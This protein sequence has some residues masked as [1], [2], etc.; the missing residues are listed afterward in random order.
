MRSCF[1]SEN[2]RKGASS[3]NERDGQAKCNGGKKFILLKNAEIRADKDAVKTEL[4][5]ILKRLNGEI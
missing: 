1:D 2:S 3:L 5:N 4:E